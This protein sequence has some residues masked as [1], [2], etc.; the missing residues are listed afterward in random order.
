MAIAFADPITFQNLWVEECPQQLPRKLR[1]AIEKIECLQTKEGIKWKYSFYS[2][3]NALKILLYEFENPSIKKPL[4][5]SSFSFESTLVEEKIDE[6]TSTF[7]N[8]E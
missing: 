1:I 5:A 8:R 7:Q 4:L 6:K 3:L 2:K